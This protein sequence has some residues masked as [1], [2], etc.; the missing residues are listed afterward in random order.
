MNSFGKAS[1]PVRWPS[2]GRPRTTGAPMA[3]PARSAVPCPAVPPVPPAGCRCKGLLNIPP[4]QGRPVLTGTLYSGSPV[5]NVRSI[6]RPAGPILT[7]VE[8]IRMA[9]RPRPVPRCPEQQ[10]FTIPSFPSAT[11]ARSQAS[12][13]SLVMAYCSSSLPSSSTTRPQ[14]PRG[15]KR[16]CLQPHA[17]HQYKGVICCSLR[18]G[19]GTG[20]ELIHRRLE[21]RRRY[22]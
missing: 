9:I 20:D 8:S 6:P 15:K 14:G 4:A 7:H 10:P 18:P 13:S 12:P 2:A 5:G 21:E 1:F 11:S 3:A 17:R 19:H 22:E 16:P